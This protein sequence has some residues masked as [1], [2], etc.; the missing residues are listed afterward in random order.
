MVEKTEQCIRIKIKINK[1]K[2]KNMKI[3]RER[4]VLNIRLGTGEM[5]QVEDFKYL[6]VHI[7]KKGKTENS[8]RERIVMGQ[9]AAGG[10]KRYGVTL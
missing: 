7:R 4:E 9:R 3:C 5:D 10:L 6:E 1:K 8:V 2:I